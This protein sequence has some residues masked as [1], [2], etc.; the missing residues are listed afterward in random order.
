MK[1]LL[2]GLALLL[3][4]LTLTACGSG[5]DTVENPREAE[6]LTLGNAIIENYVYL[7]E[8]SPLPQISEHIH[9][10]LVHEGRIYFAH[11]AETA[12]V[13]ESI[14]P[15]G[16]AASRTEIANAGTFVDIA[17]MRVTDAGNFTLIFTSAEWAY[18]GGGDVTV[19]YAEYTPQGAE[20]TR[21]EIPGLVPAGGGWFELSQAL[22]LDEGLALVADTRPGGRTFTRTV[23]L[24][25]ADFSS[26]SQLEAHDTIVMRPLAQTRDGRLILA[27][28]EDCNVAVFRFVL[29]EIDMAAGRWGETFPLMIQNNMADMVQSLHPAREG[30]AFDLYIAGR[31]NLFGYN[32]DAGEQAMVLSWLESGVTLPLEFYLNPLEDGRLSLITTE[33]V[34]LTRTARADLGEFEIITLGAL[35]MDNILQ[36]QVMEFNQRSQTHQ[37]EIVEYLDPMLDF[38]LDAAL[39]AV[40]RLIADMMIGQG[41]DIILDPSRQM[42]EA[43]LLLDL[44]PL[45][46]ADPELSRTDFFPNILRLQEVPDGALYSMSTGFQILTLVGME[47]M[48]GHVDAWTFSEMHNLMEQALRRNMTY[49]LNDF[50][51]NEVSASS[52]LLNAFTYSFCNF[53]DL[54]ENRANLDNADFIALLD[55]AARL[56]H[57]P[58]EPST[59]LTRR[60]TGSRM[61]RGEQLFNEVVIGSVN[62]Y[63]LN[64]EIF[65]EDMVFLGWPSRDGGGHAV[66][67]LQ[68]FGIAASSANPEA[69]WE[70]IRGLL[71]PDPE[72]LFYSQSQGFSLRMDDFEAAIENAMLPRY[73]PDIDGN[74]VEVSR[75]E[76][77]RTGEDHIDYYVEVIELYALTEA[78]AE[79]L[80]AIVEGATIR[81]SGLREI[82][83]MAAEELPP[84]LAG[85]RT[86]AE[87]ARILQNRVQT[88]LWER[89]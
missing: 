12:I 85:D 77:W 11:V 69:A 79:E 33:H 26:Q 67:F 22:F 71:M 38:N 48:V 24:F 25:D 1:K 23:H 28:T 30:E 15:D 45:L 51:G 13:I 78:D 3:F 88:F 76:F 83:E 57:T 70:F 55:F 87:T 52:F 20:I 84:F 86:A 44:Y 9:A 89:G 32:L 10:A 4:L 50:I 75:V 60:T 17:G 73:G 74:Q 21:R 14:L 43:G 29:R 54:E 42:E 27:D 66:S 40:A 65:G 53:I 18:Q 7:A 35:S 47:D 59:I 5:N 63:Q 64:R 56:P 6:A 49:I 80:R 34:L 31:T 68:S 82:S 46:D 61:M 16:T 36:M 58:P 19:L 62:D 8:F 81:P 2:I 41:P 39:A 72:R 37:I